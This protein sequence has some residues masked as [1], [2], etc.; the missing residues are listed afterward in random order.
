MKPKYKE[1][2]LRINNK[3]KLKN[4]CLNSYEIMKSKCK[5]YD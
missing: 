4:I 3:I 5:E 1:T 2:R